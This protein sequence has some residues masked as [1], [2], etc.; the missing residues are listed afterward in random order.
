MK[1]E[2][3]FGKGCSRVKLT[4]HAGEKTAEVWEIQPSPIEVSHLQQPG[5][6]VLSN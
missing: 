1:E 2:G 3:T 5:F 6:E 4:E